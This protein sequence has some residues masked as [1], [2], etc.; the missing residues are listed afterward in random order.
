MNTDEVIY[1]ILLIVSILLGPFLKKFEAGW[2]RQ[3]FSGV[4]GM[5]MVIVVCGKHGLHSLITVTVNIAIIKLS[6]PR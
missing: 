2:R 1:V 3:Y 4:V 5:A 6:S